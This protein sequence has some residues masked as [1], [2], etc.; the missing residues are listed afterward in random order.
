MREQQDEAQRSEVLMKIREEHQPIRIDHIQSHSFGV[1]EQA[2]LSEFEKAKRKHE[3][4][5]QLVEKQ[6][7]LRNM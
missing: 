3:D 5:L 7:V 2:K 6:R 1:Q 4:W